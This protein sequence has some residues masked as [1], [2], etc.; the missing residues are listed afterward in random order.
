MKDK[1]VVIF[2]LFKTLIDIETDETNP[3]AY[4]F[5]SSWL[6]YQGIIVTPEDFHKSL[7][8]QEKIEY[9]EN[10]NQHPDV[11]IGNVLMRVFSGLLISPALD[12]HALIRETALLFRILT[13]KYLT[14]YPQ[15]HPL[16]E[17]LYK[18]QDIRLCICSN[19]QRLFS[20]PEIRKFDL[21]K[22]FELIIFSSD[23]KARKPNPELFTAALEGMKVKPEDAIYVGDNLY[24]DVSGAQG[25]G[26]KTIW[27]DRG[28]DFNF[29]AGFR[30]PVPNERVTTK[31]YFKIPEKIY[32]LFG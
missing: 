15:T 28:I 14:V 10:P 9:E 1:K 19:T 11:D 22:Y 12:L 25:V 31:T 21:E 23:V 2:D 20:I 26:L 29:P 32:Q 27:I 16:L 8:D 17:E 3:L 30:K 18:R 7:R 24:E 4:D 6:S 13:T 5:L